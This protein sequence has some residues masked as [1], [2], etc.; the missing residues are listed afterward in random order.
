MRN[1]IKVM[2]RH[3]ATATSKGDTKVNTLC[4]GAKEKA[5]K[6]FSNS[7]TMKY[8]NCKTGL[9]NQRN[10]IDKIQRVMKIGRR[11]ASPVK[12]FFLILKGG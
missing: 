5:G 9:S 12:K 7:C 2:N 3:K 4:K 11:K 1:P 6:V 8:N 10:R